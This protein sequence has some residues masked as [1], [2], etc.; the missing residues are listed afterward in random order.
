MVQLVE[1]CLMPF[2]QQSEQM[3]QQCEVAFKAL[4]LKLNSLYHEL[5]RLQT[6][7]GKKSTLQIQC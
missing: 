5:R 3:R 4:S 2:L 6:C 1:L 7:G